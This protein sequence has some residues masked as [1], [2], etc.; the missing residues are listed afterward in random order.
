MTKEQTDRLGEKLMRGPMMF[1]AVRL[2]PMR[3][4]A[5]LLIL[6]FLIQLV[7]AFIA[8]FLLLKTCGLTY[9]QRVVFVILCGVLI[10]VAGKLVNG[11]GGVSA[12]PIYDGVWRHRYWLDPGG[13]GNREVCHRKAGGCVAYRTACGS[14][15]I[16]PTLA[17]KT[18]TEGKLCLK[19]E[20]KKNQFTASTRA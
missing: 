8:T 1:A 18:K 13:P 11:S 16:N 6:Q 2:S 17:E 12:A 4:F 19:L 20:L 7:S 9:G 3:P 5:V 15:R 10:F 14:K